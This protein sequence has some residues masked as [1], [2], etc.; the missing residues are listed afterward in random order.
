MAW[1]R[2]YRNSE[3]GLAIIYKHAAHRLVQHRLQVVEVAW[4]DDSTL[5]LHALPVVASIALLCEDV[6]V[7]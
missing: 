5:P 3:S 6:G 1:E 2:G 4:A 7:Q